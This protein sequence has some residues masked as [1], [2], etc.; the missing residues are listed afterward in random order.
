MLGEVGNDRGAPIVFI[1]QWLSTFEL[2]APVWHELRRA[3][4]PVAVVV[5][6]ER[7]VEGPS[8]PLH[9]GSEFDQRSADGLWRK[10]T[11]R[12]FE[13]LPQVA[14]SVEAQR[15][16]SLRP[17]A[18]FLATPYD[19]HRHPGLAPDV[20]GVPVH[21]ISYGL[22]ISPDVG[23]GESASSFYDHCQ[24]IYADTP[25]ERDTV[26][27]AG[28]AREAVLL[29]GHPGL[30]VWDVPHEVSPTPLVLW[31][32]WWGHS[33]PT[34]GPGYSTFLAGRHDFL[35]QVRRRPQVSF[36][37]RPHSLLWQAL[38]RDRLW[39][40]D[41]EANFFAELESLPN[42]TFSDAEADKEGHVAQLA[43]AWAMVTDGITFIEEFAYTGKPLLITRAPGNPGWNPVGEAIEQI[44]EKSDL[45][46]GLSAFLDAVERGPNA[47]R[48]IAVREQMQQVLNRPPGGAAPLV[49]ADLVRT[50][51]A[52]LSRRT[53]PA[54]TG[55]SWLTLSA[56]MRSAVAELNEAEAGGV[57]L[58]YQ[59]QL[60]E[61]GGVNLDGEATALTS[62]TVPRVHGGQ[63]VLASGRS[64]G[65]A[66]VTA[67][68]STGWQI[69]RVV[70][71]DSVFALAGSAKTESE[72]S[73]AA[74][75][76]HR[77]ALLLDQARVALAEGPPTPRVVR[78]GTTSM[79][80]D[81]WNNLPALVLWEDLLAGLLASGDVRLEI[82]PEGVAQFEALGSLG[83]L[84][85][86]LGEFARSG[87]E[88][89]PRG[90][91]PC[92]GVRVS[93]E[94][95]SRVAASLNSVNTPARE[96]PRLW[97]GIQP[98]GG[99]PTNAVALAVALATQW[100]SRTGGDVVIDAF[101]P[102]SVETGQSWREAQVLAAHHFR[103][104]VVRRAV[105]RS[106]ATGAVLSTSGLGLH[107][108]LAWAGTADYYVCT[109]G[110]LLQKVAWVWNLPGTVLV[111]PGPHR[112]SV[113]NWYSEQVEGGRQAALFPEWL[114]ESTTDGSWRVRD[115]RTAAAHVVGVAM[116]SVRN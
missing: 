12:G 73:V 74:V 75:L 39:S 4:V 20:L 28:L 47:E 58:S 94:A 56:R 68:M 35:E 72:G 101:T 38:R 116:S 8:A 37:F 63:F 69:D 13:P 6:P 82:D 90:T 25:Y 26:L 14:P 42:I 66:L 84:L 93:S 71:A 70:L 41:D 30:D 76:G 109:A 102:D 108:A 96:G 23:G 45:M 86:A 78:V 89:A 111:P 97:I 81:L 2:V 62:F 80:H 32:P 43:E 29:T 85:P 98:D 79:V 57:G 112:G 48:A 77:V 115:V 50:R 64:D 107:E 59:R 99:G 87:R 33:W 19:F 51:E 67:G 54:R 60:L 17:S 1:A 106:Q 104:E 31:C 40:A 100:R 46:V 110:P 27:G 18:V 9:D 49:A 52:E 5:A 55:G 16:R 21:Y 53:A 7:R 65:L 44:V 15:I 36:V 22:T 24:R 10:L 34:G 11:E 83:D 103:A 113:A 3:G 91:V 105:D 61:T 95:R 114:C 88:V 92:G